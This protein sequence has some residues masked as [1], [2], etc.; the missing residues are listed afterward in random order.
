MFASAQEE[1]DDAS[2]IV[3]LVMERPLPSLQIRRASRSLQTGALVTELEF[4]LR[5]TFGA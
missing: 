5:T 4:L 3:S 1:P 2:A